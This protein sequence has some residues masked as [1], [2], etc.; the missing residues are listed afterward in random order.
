MRRLR[1]CTL[2]RSLYVLLGCT[3]FICALY[4]HYS[5]IP[6]YVQRFDFLHVFAGSFVCLSVF[7]SLSQQKQVTNQPSV[8]PFSVCLWC[9]TIFANYFSRPI[10]TC[11]ANVQI[12]M[13]SAPVCPSALV[14]YHFK[15]I[16][17]LLT[18]RFVK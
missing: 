12:R 4:F 8:H 1:A 16:T 2:C 13:H 14:R 17:Y 10:S 15:A 9:V 18:Q 11:M 3:L 6:L 7:R 5:Y